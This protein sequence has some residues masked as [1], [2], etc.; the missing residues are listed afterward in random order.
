MSNDEL[1]AYGRALAADAPPLTTEQ[2]TA[3]ARL[4]AEVVPLTAA[5]S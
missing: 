1:H 3:A 4:Y 5:A 2:V